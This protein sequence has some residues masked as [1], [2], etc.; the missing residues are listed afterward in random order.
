AEDRRTLPGVGVID[1]CVRVGAHGTAGGLQG[2]GVARARAADVITDIGKIGAPDSTE[3]DEI[4]G[5]F[6]VPGVVLFIGIPFLPGSLG[7]GALV[8]VAGDAVALDGE[9][10]LQP[11][12]VDRLFVQD[13]CS[14]V[15]VLHD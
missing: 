8:V 13:G 9:V 12:A 5:L 11:A 1:R 14:V 6:G 7:D 4:D 2:D 3:V 15:C 10:C